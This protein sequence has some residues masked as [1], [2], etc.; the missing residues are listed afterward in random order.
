[1]RVWCVCACACSCVWRSASAAFLHFCLSVGFRFQPSLPPLPLALE[2][3]IDACYCV[4]LRNRTRGLLLVLWYKQ[5]TNF[6]VLGDLALK[7]VFCNYSLVRR[8][9]EFVLHSSCWCLLLP[10]E[11]KVSSFLKASIASFYS[12]NNQARAYPPTHTQ[13]KVPSKIWDL[14]LYHIC[15]IIRKIGFP[16]ENKSWI[17]IG[18]KVISIYGYS[19]A[20]SLWISNGLSW[21]KGGALP[22]I[23]GI[24]LKL[25]F[26]IRHI[27]C[28]VNNDLSCHRNRVPGATLCFALLKEGNESSHISGQES[29]SREFSGQC[30]W[31]LMSSCVHTGLENVC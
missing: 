16:G 1:M 3:Q 31:A 15:N 14:T 22:C 20:S 12:P 23:I 19:S 5:F 4:E 24:V 28:C 2:L 30:R 13:I 7:S 10:L 26:K 18:N 11:A 17:E 9:H 27:L 25:D 21:N 29:D 6:P 8:H